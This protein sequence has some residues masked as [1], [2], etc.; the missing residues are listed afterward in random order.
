M[1]QVS[2]ASQLVLNN[3]LSRAPRLKDVILEDGL[4]DQGAERKNC[5]IVDCGSIR[6]LDIRELRGVKEIEVRKKREAGDP[7]IVQGSK[8][9]KVKISTYD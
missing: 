2:C 9:I 7:I 6:S 3:V 5:L 4:L 1:L 8:S